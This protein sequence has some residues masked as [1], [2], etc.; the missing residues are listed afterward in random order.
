MPRAGRHCRWH[1]GAYGGTGASP[2]EQLPPLRGRLRDDRQL[3]GCAARFLWRSAFAMGLLRALAGSCS[4]GCRSRC[5][6]H[7]RIL[8]RKL[9]ARHALDRSQFGFLRRRIV[10]RD[11]CAA[12]AI[13]A[14]T[15]NAVHIGF[16]LVR[17]IVVHD[18][19]DTRN[20]N[21]AC[22]DVGCD[23]NSQRPVTE[24]VQRTLACIL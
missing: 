21:A 20:V 14:S 9:A 5:K 4:A 13:A 1:C 22:S 12:G 2:W 6:F 24:S 3:W 8:D 11:R 16:R 23:Q 19:A 17:Q 10:E 15:A 18:M 7:R